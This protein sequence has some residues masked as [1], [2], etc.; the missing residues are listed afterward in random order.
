MLQVAAN[1]VLINER[2]GSMKTKSLAAELLYSL[3]PSL[4]VMHG[5]NNA[6]NMNWGRLQIH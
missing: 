6:S 3:S 2:N 4:H 5:L 1:R